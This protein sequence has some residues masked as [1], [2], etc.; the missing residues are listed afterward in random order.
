[1]GLPS[2]AS[3]DVNTYASWYSYYAAGFVQDDWRVRHNLTVNVGLRY[4]HDG[5]YQE[6]YGRTVDLTPRPPILWR[7]LRKRRMPRVPSPSFR[8]V[9]LTFR[10]V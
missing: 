9:L 3:Y 1:M 8:S 5:P 2:S 6:K 10:E 4:E 7:P